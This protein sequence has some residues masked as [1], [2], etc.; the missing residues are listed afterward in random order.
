MKK[1]TTIERARTVQRNFVAWYLN[2]GRGGVTRHNALVAFYNEDTQDWRFSFVKLD[3]AMVQDAKGNVKISTEFTPAKRYSFLVGEHE[4][5][6][7]AQSRLVGLLTKDYPL[8]SEIEEAFNVEKVSKEFFANYKEL[9][10][11][12][13]DNLNNLNK[14]RYV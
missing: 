7:T 9:F 2:G 12:L 11:Q 3:T 8:V 6:H 5:N 14:L 13:V 1:N 10:L 4:P